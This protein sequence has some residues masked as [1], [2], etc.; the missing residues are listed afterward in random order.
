MARITHG[1]HHQHAG[2]GG[3]IDPGPPA[4]VPP[5]TPVDPGP[6]APPAAPAFSDLGLTFNDATR[7]L[8]GGLWQNVVSEGGQG[9]GSIGRYT[10]DLT[11]VQT[12]LQAEVAAGQFT[13]ATLAHVNAILA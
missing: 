2:N 13:G 3:Q 11:N 4:P 7:A 6:P 12:G 5:V 10:T 1:F 8:E 9:L